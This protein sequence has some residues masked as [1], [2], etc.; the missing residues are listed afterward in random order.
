LSDGILHH[1]H[2]PRKNID[3]I[4]LVIKQDCLPRSLGRTAAKAFHDENTHL[5]MLRLYETISA[6]YFWQKMLSDLENYAGS[7]TLCQQVNSAKSTHAT[8][9]PLPVPQ[10]LL[11][12][13]SDW[14][15]P[16]SLSNGNRYILVCVDSAT[17]FP[18][19]FAAPKCDAEQSQEFFTRKFVIDMDVLKH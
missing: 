17:L 6:R 15:G 9:Q 10:P 8:L 4:I 12:W 1:L 11:V 13:H 19:I 3:K 16:L 14:L 5:G 18:E 2:R 7:C